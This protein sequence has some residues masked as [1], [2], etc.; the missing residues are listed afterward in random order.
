ME[1]ETLGFYLSGHPV[2]DYFI[3]IKTTVTNYI[4]RVD[5]EMD[6]RNVVLAGVVTKIKR[7]VTKKGQAMAYL[8]LEDTTG[9]IECIVFPSILE[10]YVEFLQ[11]DK[12]IKVEGRISNQNDELKCIVSTITKL[13]K[14]PAKKLYLKLGSE[15]S[16]E[17]LEELRLVLTRNKGNTPVFLDFTHKGQR[18]L[19][20][21]DYWVEEEGSL[22]E[23]LPKLDMIKNIRVG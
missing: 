20:S 6:G 11:E 23:L 17:H 1:K 22:F 7:T 15:I 10:K 19:T 4:D 5:A 13:Q 9:S 16:I 8:S 3:N 18:I 12:V 21:R 14:D 2:E